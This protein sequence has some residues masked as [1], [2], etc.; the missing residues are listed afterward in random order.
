[1]L[2]YALIYAGTGLD[3]STNVLGPEV[4]RMVN[5][6]TTR[7]CKKLKDDLPSNTRN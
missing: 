4:T 6:F 1:M 7:K 2:A 3:N 5:E